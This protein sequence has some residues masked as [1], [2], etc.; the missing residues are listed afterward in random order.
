MSVFTRFDVT[1]S[2]EYDPE[3]TFILNA[4][5][6]R[7]LRPFVYKVGSLD[8]NVFVEV[9]RNYITDFASVPWF[10]RWLVPR[11]GSHGQAAILHDWLCDYHVVQETVG[12][13]ILWR[14]ISRKRV[15]HIF[16][17]AMRVAKVP[18]YRRWLIQIGVSG[19]RWVARPR[20]PQL[21]RK[22]VALM[23]RYDQEDWEH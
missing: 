18:A 3:A 5:H 23:A 6:W 21:H 19:Y 8:S 1:A 12:D 22:K 10:A 9:P 17:E 15:D 7:L 16:Y 2:V 11:H 13:K 20:K 14:E 4:E